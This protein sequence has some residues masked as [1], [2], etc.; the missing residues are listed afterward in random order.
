MGS[1]ASNTGLTTLNSNKVDVGYLVQDNPISSLDDIPVNSVGRAYIAGSVAPSSGNVAVN[2]VC[3][4]RGNNR[5]L[6]ISTASNNT[7]TCVR[8]GGAWTS[9]VQLN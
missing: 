7:Y 4:G 8:T 2:Y 5:C 1:C 3:F 6:L 9:W